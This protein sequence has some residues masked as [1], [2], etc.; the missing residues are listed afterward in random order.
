ME[1]PLTYS[2]MVSPSWP[3]EMAL[4][5]FSVLS[6]LS[7]TL[8]LLAW[9]LGLCLVSTA[10][11]GSGGIGGSP[12]VLPLELWSPVFQVQGCWSLLWWLVAS[13]S[14]VPSWLPPGPSSG[15]S[16]SIW[17]PCSSPSPHSI[18][19]GS[20]WCGHW[21]SSWGHSGNGVSGN[22]WGQNRFYSK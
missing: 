14:C 15:T 20:H 16:L 11:L 9:P 6:W 7:Q 4:Q 2:P 21:V 10:S 8:V 17:W 19:A 3:L 1:S 13:P 22:V 5:T 12:R 18:S